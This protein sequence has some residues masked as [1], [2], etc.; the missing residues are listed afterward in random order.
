[1]R[2]D[3]RDPRPGPEPLPVR[4]GVEGET[5]SGAG[6]FDVSSDGTLAWVRAE[7]GDEQ[8]E[9]GWLD[10]AG[11]WT[12][13]R[14]PRGPYQSVRLSPDGSRALICAGAGGGASDLWIGDLA[15]GGMNRLTYG[16]A[17]GQG[18]WL[19]DGLRMVFPLGDS[20]GGNA[21]VVRRLDGAGAERVLFRAPWP[22]FA[23]DITPDGGRVLIADYGRA[24]GRIRVA[25]VDGD[26]S[27]RE[28][29][30]DPGNERNEQAGVVSPD[31]RWLAY[32]SNRTRREEVYIRAFDGVGGRWQ[33]STRGGGGVR[34]GRDSRELFFVEQGRE[35]VMRVPLVSHGAEL[36]VGQPEPLFEATSSPTEP[37][38][39]DMD[40]DRA[41]DRFLFTRPPGGIRERR[42]IELSLGWTSRLAAKAREGRTAK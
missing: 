14:L 41:H 18:L 15:T 19:H 30:P 21:I 9:I 29:P 26:P 5:S 33:V 3:P 17:S 40:Y 31:G 6:F 24:Q 13:T 10:R 2:I 39:R 4:D 38:Y 1:M 42:G 25:N 27:P 32:V 8:R 35:Q 12:A 7:A 22:L 11:R 34:W 28:L 36:M 23:S 37:T 16:N 20:A